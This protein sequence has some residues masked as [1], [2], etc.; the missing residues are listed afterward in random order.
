MVAQEEVL[1]TLDTALPTALALVVK[2]I[3]AAE[4]QR[5]VLH[6]TLAAGEGRVVLV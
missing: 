1:G 5:V 4:E 3:T 6:T 2:G